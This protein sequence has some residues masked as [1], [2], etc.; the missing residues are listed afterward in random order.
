MELQPKLKYRPIDLII[1]EYKKRNTHNLEIFINNELFIRDEFNDLKR[2]PI[3]QEDLEKLLNH[4][5]IKE[6]HLEQHKNLDKSMVE[7]IIKIIRQFHYDVQMDYFVQYP[8]TIDIIQHIR[9]ES[10]IIHVDGDHFY[11]LLDICVSKL[12]K[13]ELHLATLFHPRMNF[14]ALSDEYFDD[15]EIKIARRTTYVLVL[16]L[17]QI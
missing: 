14:F 11:D 3:L 2:E 8:A 9:C 16:T 17:R 1:N 5:T 6:I 13:G 4:L 7:F 12:T 10:L 15:T